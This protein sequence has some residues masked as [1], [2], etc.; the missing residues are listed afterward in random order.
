MKRYTVEFAD[1]AEEDLFASYEWGCRWVQVI[2]ESDQARRIPI[3]FPID[4]RILRTDEIAFRVGNG[5]NSEEVILI[6]T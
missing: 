3:N 1:S 4:L 2:L 5:P 6:V